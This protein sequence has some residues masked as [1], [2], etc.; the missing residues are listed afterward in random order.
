MPNYVQVKIKANTKADFNKLYE[1]LVDT[2]LVDGETGE[3]RIDFNRIIPMPKNIFRGD[4]GQ[5][6]HELY[7]ENNWYDWSVKNWGTK[8]NA[9]YSIIDA[10]EN[11]I[12]F[13]TA[14]S[15]PFPIIDKLLEK[16]PDISFV[17]EFAGEDL[18]YNCGELV[19][20]NGE[21]AEEYWPDRGTEEA[22]KFACEVWGY[23]Y[24]EL[25]KERN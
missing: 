9:C 10:D 4:L 1:V 3:P 24:E 14:W 16:L 8:W 11:I 22:E 15:A 5:K 17:F 23:D 18:G 13:Q 20:E 21:Y 19:V 7:G 2:D 12:T 6:E 25:L